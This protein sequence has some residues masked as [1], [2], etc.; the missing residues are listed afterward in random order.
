MNWN[1]LKSAEK[2]T[3]G[4]E[5]DHLAAPLATRLLPQRAPTTSSPTPAAPSP[6]R[7]D[8]PAGKLSFKLGGGTVAA[9]SKVSFQFK[10]N[11]R[12]STLPMNDE[13]EEEDSNPAGEED[14]NIERTAAGEYV[15]TRFKVS[16][17]HEM[18]RPSQGGPQSLTVV[19][20]SSSIGGSA[21]SYSQTNVNV[22]NVVFSNAVPTG[23]IEQVSKPI[24]HSDQLDNNAPRVEKLNDESKKED[25]LAGKEEE[26]DKVSMCQSRQG[27]EESKESSSDSKL[28]TD[29]QSGTDNK[30]E[31]RDLGKGKHEDHDREDFIHK[32]LGRAKEI[33]EGNRKHRK[34][35]RN[36]REDTDEDRRYSRRVRERKEEIKDEPQDDEKRA[37]EHKR[38]DEGKY[39]DK[40]VVDTS[41]DRRRHRGG[42]RG[43]KDESMDEQERDEYG[44][45]DHKRRV[46][47]RDQSRERGRDKEKKGDR[48][49]GEMKEEKEGRYQ[50]KRN[51]E[52]VKKNEDARGVRDKKDDTRKKEENEENERERTMKIEKDQYKTEDRRNR[53]GYKDDDNDSRERESKNK[54]RERTSDRQ[55]DSNMHSKDDKKSKGEKEKDK[56]MQDKNE[57]ERREDSKRN[58]HVTEEESANGE[59]ENVR[60]QYITNR[61][62]TYNNA[63]KDSNQ[64]RRPSK[65]EDCEDNRS[66][67]RQPEIQRVKD[68][69]RK[70]GE[71]EVDN[72]NEYTPTEKEKDIINKDEETEINDNKDSETICAPL[73]PQMSFGLSKSPKNVE[74]VKKSLY[75]NVKTDSESDAAIYQDLKSQHGRG[76]GKDCVENEAKV[77]FTKSS[78]LNTAT[79]RDLNIFIK[80]SNSETTEAHASEIEEKRDQN[81]S[82]RSNILRKSMKHR[83]ERR[84]QGRDYSSSSSS[85]STSSTSSSSDSESNSSD[86]SKTKKDYSRQSRLSS[87]HWTERKKKSP[88]RR[89]EQERYLLTRPERGSNQAVRKSSRFSTVEEKR[90]RCS[91]ESSSLKSHSSPHKDSQAEEVL[92]EV[93]LVDVSALPGKSKWEMDEEEEE[94][95]MK[96]IPSY[97]SNQMISFGI[98]SV[99]GS[100]IKPLNRGKMSQASYI[101]RHTTYH[102]S[103]VAGNPDLPQKSL[104]DSYDDD[105]PTERKKDSSEKSKKEETSTSGKKRHKERKQKKDKS[106]KKSK[107]KKKLEDEKKSIQVSKDIESEKDKSENLIAEEDLRSQKH[108]K[109]ENVSNDGVQKDIE[110]TTKVL[111]LKKGMHHAQINDRAISPALLEESSHKQVAKSKSWDFEED[112]ISLKDK[113]RKGKSESGKNRDKREKSLSPITKRKYSQDQRERSQSPNNKR[114]GID[115]SPSLLKE[116]KDS[117]RLP[118]VEKDDRSPVL[119]KNRKESP[120]SAKGRKDKSLSPVKDEKDRSA[121]TKSRKSKSPSPAK[122]RKDR[123]PL[124]NKAIEE[125]SPSPRKIRKDRSPSPIKIRK[126]ESSSPAKTRKDKSPSPGK[127]RESRADS[128]AKASKSD[129]FSPPKDRSLSPTTRSKDRSMSPT[130]AKDDKSSLKNRIGS[131]KVKKDISPFSGMKKSRSPSPAHAI[132]DERSQP[133]DRKRKDGSPPSPKLIEKIRYAS[134]GEKSRSPS[135]VEDKQ[136]SSPALKKSRKS[137]SPS[138][139]K[140]KDNRSPSIAKGKGATKERT[141][142]STRNSESKEGSSSHDRTLTSS[143]RSLSKDRPSSRSKR[144]HSKDNFS[145]TKRSRSKER[146]S[147]R[148]KRSGSRDRREGSRGS[149]TKHREKSGR[150]RSRSRSYSRSNKSRSPDVRQGNRKSRSRSPKQSDRGNSSRSSST[151][152]YRRDHSRSRSSDR[153]RFSSSR[154]RGRSPITDKYRKMSRGHSRSRSESIESQSGQQT[155]T[156]LVDNKGPTSGHRKRIASPEK[157]YKSVEMHSSTN[158]QTSSEKEVSVGEIPD[159]DSI[160]MPG[161]MLPEQTETTKAE[162]RKEAGK[163]ESDALVDKEGSK[164]I[165]AEEPMEISDEEAKDEDNQ[166]ESLGVTVVMQEHFKDDVEDEK[167][168]LKQEVKTGT[169]GK[170]RAA[171]PLGKERQIKFSIAGGSKKLRPVKLVSGA[172]VDEDEED[173]VSQRKKASTDRLRAKSPERAIDSEKQDESVEVKSEGK[174]D[175]IRENLAKPDFLSKGAVQEEIKTDR[176]SSVALNN[177]DM[178]PDKGTGEDVANKSS[179]IKPE[180]KR[181]KFTYVP[182]WEM[183]EREKRPVIKLES[184]PQNPSGLG[185]ALDYGSGSSD[186]EDE[187]S[188]VKRNSPFK[189]QEAVVQSRNKLT[190]ANDGTSLPPFSEKLKKLDK[191]IADVSQGFPEKTS[192]ESQVCSVVHSSVTRFAQPQESGSKEVQTDN[193]EISQLYEEVYSPSHPSLEEVDDLETPTNIS[194][195]GSSEKIPQ[196]QGLSTGSLLS[197]DSS[198]RIPEKIG[199]VVQNLSASDT[200]VFP[201]ANEA[202]NSVTAMQFQRQIPLTL[203]VPTILPITIQGSGLVPAS[204]QSP[205]LEPVPALA[206]GSTLIPEPAPVPVPA[207]VCPPGPVPAPVHVPGSMPVLVQAPGLVPAPVKVQE[208]M[209]AAFHVQGPLHALASGSTPTPE[210][211]PGPVP[212]PVLPPG[213]VPAPVQASRSVLISVQAPVP[214]PVCPPGPMPAPVHVP[215]PVPMPVQAFERMPAP[216]LAPASIQTPKLISAPA[217]TSGLISAYAH[218]S[219]PLPLHTS[220]HEQGPVPAP[221]VAPATNTPAI[222]FPLF[223]PTGTAASS[224][225]SKS[226]LPVSTQAADISVTTGS[227]K[228]PTDT[229]DSLKF[230][231]NRFDEAAKT[232]KIAQESA[233]PVKSPLGSVVSSSSGALKERRK[234]GLSKRPRFSSILS[235]PKV[236]DESVN[237]KEARPTF[238][239]IPLSISSADLKPN[240]SMHYN[241]QTT[242]HR[243]VDP[244][245]DG[246]SKMISQD[247][248]HL[249]PQSSNELSNSEPETIIADSGPSKSDVS[250]FVIGTSNMTSESPC[251]SNKNLKELVESAK[252]SELLEKISD[253]KREAVDLKE[254]STGL[255]SSEEINMSDLDMSSIPLP[256]DPC[257]SVDRYESIHKME[258]APTQAPVPQSSSETIFKDVPP[259]LPSSPPPQPPLPPQPPAQPD[260]SSSPSGT[261]TKGQTLG[262]LLAERKKRFSQSPLAIG[263]LPK[264]PLPQQSP[265]SIGPLPKLPPEPESVTQVSSMKQ[266]SST[267]SSKI[268]MVIKSKTPIQRK[269]AA[270]FD[271]DGSDGS[272]TPG[273]VELASETDSSS[274]MTAFANEDMEDTPPPPPPPLPPS[275]ALG[276][277]LEPSSESS[278]TIDETKTLDVGVEKDSFVQKPKAK[279]VSLTDIEAFPV[280]VI[281]SSRKEEN[282]AAATWPEFTQGKSSKKDEDHDDHRKSKEKERHRDKDKDEKR[283]SK[284]REKADDRQRRPDEIT[285]KRRSRQEDS[286]GEKRQRDKRRRKEPSSGSSNKAEAIIFDDGKRKIKTEKDDDGDYGDKRYSKSKSSRSGRDDSKRRSQNDSRDDDDY[287][288]RRKDRD[289]RGGDHRN[290]SYRSSRDD[291]GSFRQRAGDG[292]RRKKRYE[293]EADRN[294]R[295]KQVKSREGDT[296]RRSG[297]TKGRGRS[298]SP[299]YRRDKYKR[300]RSSSSSGSSS[301]SNSS[302]SRSPIKD[303]DRKGRTAVDRKKDSRRQYKEPVHVEELASASSVTHAGDVFPVAAVVSSVGSESMPSFSEEYRPEMAYGSVPNYPPTTSEPSF[304]PTHQAPPAP[305]NSF[306]AQSHLYPGGQYAPNE[307]YDSSQHQQ[308][309]NSYWPEQPSS[310]LYTQGQQQQT[311]SQAPLSAQQQ[312]PSEM[313]GQY[314]PMPQE[315]PPHQP[316]GTEQYLYQQSHTYPGQD[317]MYHGGQVPPV[318]QHQQQYLPGLTNPPPSCMPDQNSSQYPITQPPTFPVD[319]ANTYF[320]TTQYFPQESHQPNVVQDTQV[321]QRSNLVSVKASAILHQSSQLRTSKTFGSPHFPKPPTDPKSSPTLSGSPVLK[322]LI[323]STTPTGKVSIRGSPLS[324]TAVSSSAHRNSPTTTSSSTPTSSSS[325]LSQKRTILDEPGFG[326]DIT[327]TKEARE[328][329]K[330]IKSSERTKEQTKAA[331]VNEPI[332]SSSSVEETAHDALDVSRTESGSLKPLKVRDL[333]IRI[334]HIK[335]LSLRF[336]LNF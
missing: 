297:G 125:R 133:S 329:E 94:Q 275:A 163:S 306:P 320:Q 324:R 328:V 249:Q 203:P 150:D 201:P 185:L 26:K 57:R 86:T 58:E 135:L 168:N 220:T 61:P 78:M 327:T 318:H 146:P 300:G 243:E 277:E 115:R 77:S 2:I 113:R 195:V 112:N 134:S 286:D 126:D 334:K 82:G 54:D 187:S 148:T 137:E 11:L 319:P 70:Y 10:R 241:F 12:G 176:E 331:E 157:D 236:E 25:N 256:D 330:G 229:S 164:D 68:L 254:A 107:T 19:F 85:S 91:E 194:Q 131:R 62:D 14:K 261:T 308:F 55:E 205:G 302:S 103:A 73:S 325:E 153:W 120:T 274:L 246:T 313:S 129:S 99:G 138:I 287:H 316:M 190:G 208:P 4:G 322:P 296:H 248:I 192:L 13:E 87:D 188:P 181:H 244:T 18:F 149:W 165:I 315:L 283:R 212:V 196:K 289:F 232:S 38:R 225:S 106:E 288:N 173:K 294:R 305:D 41:R 158:K 111:P 309:G 278:K 233:A 222:S 3:S 183:E 170:S 215:G 198:K 35:K 276:S 143:K 335:F 27:K 239:P 49:E 105:S 80:A 221:V 189:G 299:A 66:N 45:R 119:L 284:E 270:G 44:G 326:F 307:L 52:R 235:Q 63:I 216:S 224:K 304:Y 332:V 209:P 263:L 227:L 56:T 245:R 223:G 100:S 90:E 34:D 127:L 136:V 156:S 67:A 140:A 174:I 253:A 72:E 247:P 59:K 226:T 178:Q 281:T 199:S 291:S 22:S 130:I 197:S 121:F 333:I 40:K 310:D 255:V 36:E 323:K 75:D 301:S 92:P 101:P 118:A 97:K 152:R 139:E 279:V 144:S 172:L 71:I 117:T 116:T 93:V 272:S 242:G 60:G 69:Q 271:D 202:L 251:T 280:Q 193:S 154:R 214:A 65:K 7:E 114:D 17:K 321:N 132:E 273:Q 64:S 95:E 250:G 166:E 167:T 317:L 23:D 110:S 142:K 98:T 219:V 231:M 88:D 42:K 258:S 74:K 292:D 20:D 269:L 50:E 122:S 182:L 336:E 162:I 48:K 33:A 259:P 76:A 155:K 39:D 1:F 206:S 210:Q 151:G 186:F 108:G 314:H 171:Q 161:E 267:G 179:S 79:D 31:G 175:L 295:N 81:E 109:L 180:P 312:H 240:D 9:K 184:P 311:I 264:V 47:E 6:H 230:R 237:M 290:T 228:I 43:Q 252:Q 293:D 177:Q 141:S 160:P 51:K 84:G 104:V 28:N 159:I 123:S 24:F 128:P 83:R 32:G 218:I 102:L 211:V 145:R 257:S 21:L 265:L 169:K 53:K 46:E 260:S 37:R 29:S 266:K 298:H 238:T 268:Q 191:N 147:Y 213:S 96:Q 200:I 15:P 16:K 5:D 207:P 285:E 303:R 282:T 234:P 89:K 8:K 262:S 30:R 124:P 217:P 204:V